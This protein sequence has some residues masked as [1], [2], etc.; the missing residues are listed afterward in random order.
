MIILSSF[1]VPNIYR[2]FLVISNH[3]LKADT[4]ESIINF[5][6]RLNVLNLKEMA[7]YHFMKNNVS[8]PL[9]MVSFQ[10][11]NS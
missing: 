5:L 2:I 3:S 9:N 8:L 7:F 6:F 4:F 11:D 1:F 10:P